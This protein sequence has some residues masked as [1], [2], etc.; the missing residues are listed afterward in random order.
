MKRIEAILTSRR[1]RSR[2]FS[3]RTGAELGLFATEQNKG[4]ILVRLKPRGQRT[5]S[6]EEV[7]DELR[8]ELRARLPGVEI[9]FVQ[10]LQ[11]MIGDLE[12]DA[13]RRSR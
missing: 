4:D 6:A 2:A 7:I 13:R 11:D 12:G 9:E 3:R 5:R 10:L 1:P 8:A